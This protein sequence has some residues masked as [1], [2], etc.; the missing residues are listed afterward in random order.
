MRCLPVAFGVPL[1]DG[2]QP[3]ILRQVILGLTAYNSLS[4]GKS[5]SICYKPSRSA[6]IVPVLNWLFV[7]TR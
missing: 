5:S 1:A 3:D 4:C 2:A 7:Q 6:M